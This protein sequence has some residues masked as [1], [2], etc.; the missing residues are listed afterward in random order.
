MGLYWRAHTGAAIQSYEICGEIS[1]S[2]CVKTG[3]AEKVKF[4]LNFFLMRHMFVRQDFTLL[5][6]EG[7]EIFV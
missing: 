3:E 6:V 5:T 4:L 2:V 7:D 1:E